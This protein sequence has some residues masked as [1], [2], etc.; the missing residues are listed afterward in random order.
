MPRIYSERPR[1]LLR[2]QQE[3]LFAIRGEE[4]CCLY[5]P[6][7]RAVGTCG[8]GRVWHW[9]SRVLLETRD[10]G[11][12]EGGFSLPRP[13]ACAGGDISDP[14]QCGS[15]SLSL[16]DPQVRVSLLSRLMAPWL[17]MRTTQE[18]FPERLDHLQDPHLI[19]GE[20]PTHLCI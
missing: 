5:L 3:C 18:T 17:H 4:R 15:S 14:L 19:H 20:D 1:R 13:F 10:H 2:G 9:A 11:R 7:H 16:L 6:K 8:S 12:Q